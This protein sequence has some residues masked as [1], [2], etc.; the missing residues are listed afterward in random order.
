MR[1]CMLFTSLYLNWRRNY[2][3]KLSNSVVLLAKILFYSINVRFQHHTASVKIGYLNSQMFIWRFDKKDGNF[4]S[5]VLVCSRATRR[6]FGNSFAQ[7]CEA[8]EPRISAQ[9]RSGFDMTYAMEVF[10]VYL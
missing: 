10:P 8:H 7:Q 4:F 9:N 6:I 2:D 5:E 3:I 1:A